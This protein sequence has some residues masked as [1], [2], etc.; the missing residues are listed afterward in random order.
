MEDH[1][2]FDE[3]QEHRYTLPHPQL[4]R[5]DVH[6]EVAELRQ[7]VN[8]LTGEIRELQRICRRMDNHISFVEGLYSTVRTPA[9]YVLNRVENWMGRGAQSLPEASPTGPSQN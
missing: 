9:Q 1:N 8:T 7:D 3:F 4:F 5:P 2:D 6:T